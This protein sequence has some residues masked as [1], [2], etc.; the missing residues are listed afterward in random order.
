MREVAAITMRLC[1]SSPNFDAQSIPPIK[2]TKLTRRI[3]E[4]GVDT[5]DRMMS[6]FPTRIHYANLVTDAGTVL[7]FN[8]FHALLINPNYPDVVIP[9]DT[10]ENLNFNSENY[11]LAFRELIRQWGRYHVEPVSIICDNC[12]AQVNGVAQALAFYE[13]LTILHNPCLNHIVNLVFT[14]AMQNPLVEARINL[15]GDVIR[16]ARSPVGLEILQRTCPTPV[17]TRW[18]YAVDVLR[19]L[20][21][22]RNGVNTVRHLLGHEPIPDQFVT[23]YWIM[24]PLKLFSLNMETRIRRLFQVLPIAQE[25]LREFHMVMERLEQPEDIQILDIVTARFRAHLSANA[26]SRYSHC[27]GAQ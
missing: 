11:E 19:F 16:D 3:R 17:Q 18:V 24:F 6:D 9:L 12:P 22:Q 2:P 7:G 1:R 14:H 25:T 23:L 4:I 20:L 10:Y 13:E 27:M 21:E 26:F 5:F 8:A 15:V